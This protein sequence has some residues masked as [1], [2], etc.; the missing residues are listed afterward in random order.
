VASGRRIVADGRHLLVGDVPAALGRAI[1][2]LND[3]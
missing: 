3:R 1:A 2:A